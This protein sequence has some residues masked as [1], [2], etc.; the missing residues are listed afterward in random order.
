MSNA[1]DLNTRTWHQGTYGK[2][3]HER[4]FFTQANGDTNP[5]THIGAR[6]PIGIF[7]ID[8]IFCITTVSNASVTAAVG[9]KSIVGTNQDQAGFFVAA[10]QSLAALAKVRNSVV[11]PNG[12]PFITA[13]EMYIQLVIGGAAVTQAVASEL[14]VFYVNVGTP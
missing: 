13:Q 5:S 7:L 11:P 1:A 10:G 6:V 12:T 3:S 9:V 14:H 2:Y 4:V 8:S